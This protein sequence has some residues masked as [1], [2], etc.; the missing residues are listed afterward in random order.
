[1]LDYIEANLD[2][3]LS[4]A[5]LARVANFSACHFHR[6]FRG[7]VGETLNQCI[8]RRRVEKA[9]SFLLTNPTRPIT[10]IVLDCGLSGSASFARSFKEAFGLSAS[11]YRSAGAS[12]K[13]KIGKNE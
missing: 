8:L 1:V 5:T 6:V 7:V 12:A 11:D 10:D 4:L 2:G 9:A 3:D 13:S